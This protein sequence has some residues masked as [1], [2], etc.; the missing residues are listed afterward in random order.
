MEVE[1]MEFAGKWAYGIASLRDNI[2]IN[3]KFQG[4]PHLRYAVGYKVGEDNSE[5]LE[6]S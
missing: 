1:S 6:C 5:G 4:L 2:A 3:N